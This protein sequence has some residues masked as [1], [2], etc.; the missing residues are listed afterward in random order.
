M[1]PS[2]EPAVLPNDLLGLGLVAPVA[3]HRR[4]PAGHQLALHYKKSFYMEMSPQI[5]EQLQDTSFVAPVKTMQQS[6]HYD[7][8]E[9]DSKNHYGADEAEQLQKAT[10]TPAST[11]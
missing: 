5:V 9:A 4:V 6:E 8:D 11:T 3:Q 1:L 2:V 10:S 7:A